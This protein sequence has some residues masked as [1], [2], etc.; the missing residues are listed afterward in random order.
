MG[1]VVDV[2]TEREFCR[3]QEPPGAKAITADD[4]KKFTWVKRRV[5]VECRLRRVDRERTT[6]ASAIREH[7]PRQEA[8]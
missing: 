3:R 5:V 7:S 1:F 8:E 6:E 2:G 4:M